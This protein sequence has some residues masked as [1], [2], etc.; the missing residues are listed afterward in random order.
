[1]LGK[2]YCDDVI[3]PW[4]VRIWDMIVNLE[5]KKDSQNVKNTEEKEWA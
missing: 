1:M 2:A 4:G 3:V 5:T